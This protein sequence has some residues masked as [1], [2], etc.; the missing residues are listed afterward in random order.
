MIGFIL[1]K[2]DMYFQFVKSIILMFLSLKIPIYHN[3]Y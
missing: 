3:I 2:G 1:C